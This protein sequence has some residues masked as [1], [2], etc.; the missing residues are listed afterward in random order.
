MADP[1]DYKLDISG[2]TPSNDDNEASSSGAER[3]FLRVL[4][5]CCNVYLRVY[6]QPG[7]KYYAAACPR[8]GKSVRFAVGEGGTDARDF[9]V[10]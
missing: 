8:C 3:P 7:A 2:L 6:R 10:R 9:V 5:A 4:F 1:R